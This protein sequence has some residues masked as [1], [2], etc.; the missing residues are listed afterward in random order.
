VMKINKSMGMISAKKP[1]A[2][3]VR[4]P[5]FSISKIQVWT[6]QNCYVRDGTRYCGMWNQIAFC[7]EA[8]DLELVQ[9]ACSGFCCFARSLSMGEVYGEVFDF[10]LFHSILL[11]SL[12]RSKLCV[13]VL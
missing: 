8:N 4:T 11:H 1:C 6:D 3:I 9:A 10:P 12:L 2:N 5:S 7:A 13:N